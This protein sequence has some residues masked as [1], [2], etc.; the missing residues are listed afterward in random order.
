MLSYATRPLV[1]IIGMC[2][3]FTSGMVVAAVFDSS[4]TAMVRLLVVARARVTFLHRVRRV[5]GVVDQ[6]AADLAAKHA[7]GFVHVEDGGVVR[8]RT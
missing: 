3:L 6:R 2:V 8:R 5:T 7:P 4:P 1:D